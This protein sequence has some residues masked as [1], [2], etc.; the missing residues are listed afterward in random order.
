MKNYLIFI[1][2]LCVFFCGCRGIKKM[3]KP[4]VRVIDTGIKSHIFSVN[5]N[6]NYF[7]IRDENGKISFWNRKGKCFFDQ[8]EAEKNL[9]GQK[10]EKN[11]LFF[12]KEN[13]IVDDKNKLIVGWNKGD[14]TLTY[15]RIADNKVITDRRLYRRGKIVD[16]EFAEN[17]EE[18]YY[19]VRLDNRIACCYRY[20]GKGLKFCRINNLERAVCVNYRKLPDF[21][22][23]TDDG[24][25][26]KGNISEQENTKLGFKI[27]NIKNCKI[28]P[29]GHFGFLIMDEMGFYGLDYDSNILF[30]NL[31]SEKDTFDKVRGICS[32]NGNYMVF[33]KTSIFTKDNKKLT[34]KTVSL[35]D[36]Q[37][38][39]EVWTK[40]SLFNSVECLGVSDSGDIIIRDNNRLVK[41]NA[42]YMPVDEYEFKGNII[43]C[44]GTEKCIYVYTD[45]NLV[46]VITL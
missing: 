18:A 42:D 6:E 31:F 10:L 34:E 13:F 41:Y 16:I 1:L 38:E 7:Q 5:K 22:F 46:Y 12:G 2:L 30:Y 9:S 11:R 35:Y 27:D 29:L 17:R 32:E 43:C 44:Q 40:G 28:Y 14:S 19:T 8:K 4:D 36:Y 21:Y 15:F 24:C 26:Y 45:Y 37:E 33:E 23:I 3:S 25:Y 39:K 20:K